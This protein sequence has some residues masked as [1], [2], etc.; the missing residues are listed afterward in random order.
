MS[1]LKLSKSDLWCMLQKRGYEIEV[2]QKDD[3][4]RVLFDAQ[5]AMSPLMLPR[6]FS[7]EYTKEEIIHNVLPDLLAWSGLKPKIVLDYQ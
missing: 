5:F 7:L 3:T 1:T 4:Q 2:Y 6:S